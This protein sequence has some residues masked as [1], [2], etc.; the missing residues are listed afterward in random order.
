M[1]KNFSIG[2]DV[3]LKT[4]MRSNLLGVDFNYHVF[5]GK[6]VPNPKW[7]DSDY[8][9]IHT[10][11]PDYP[12]SHIHKKFIIGYE[13]AQERTEI[14]IF[15]VKS[16]SKGNV[17]NVISENGHISCDCVGFQ[18]RRHCKHSAKVKEHL[19]KKSA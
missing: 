14:R 10:G 18:F 9:S 6:I 3:E 15:R 17:Y 1:I 4:K 16:K 7:L 12:V 8:V 13:F 5:K 2:A 19:A 11:K